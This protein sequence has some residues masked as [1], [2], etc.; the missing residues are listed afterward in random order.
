MLNRHLATL[1]LS[2][3]LPA[4]AGQVEMQRVAGQSSAILSTYRSSVRDFAAGQN[5][6]NAANE[7][8]L[9]QLG[10]MRAMR[11]AEVD[12][13]TASWRLAGDAEAQRRMAVISEMTAD[14]ILANAG[15][16]PQPAKVPTLTYDSGDVDAIIKQLVELQKS[17]STAQR[18]DELLA[19]GS[20]LREAYG[21]AIDDA[22][23]DAEK[24]GDTATE[25]EASA[26]N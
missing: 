19:Y 12:V 13:R 9:V 23:G 1:A 15:P 11:R 5:A 17:E 21:K 14:Q 4:C 8:R 7:N 20:A 10:R 2:L 22:K 18:L 3:A 26:T 6:L 16:A 24:A 25:A